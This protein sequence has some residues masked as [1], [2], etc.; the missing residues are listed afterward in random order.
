MNTTFVTA[1]YYVKDYNNP[2]KSIEKYFECF[3]KLINTGILLSVYISPEYKDQ[4]EELVKDHAN[5]KIAKVMAIQDTWVYKTANVG[6]KLPSNR[7]VLKDTFDYM[8]CQ[9]TKIECLYYSIQ[10]NYFN[11]DQFAWIDFGIFHVLND[12]EKAT[13]LLKKIA[14]SQLKDS[15]VFPGC[16][17]K[18]YAYLDGV[19]WRLCGGFFMGNKNKLIDMWKRYQAFLPQFIQ[20]YNLMTW[21]VNLWAAMEMETDFT[22]DWYHADHNLTILNIPQA[23]FLN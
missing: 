23:Y 8:V 21:E 15:L 22:F 18:G 11:T 6:I 2:G 9:N 4:L 3:K 12:F 17:N 20:K 13:L 14:N 1:F 5:V 7:N 10:E 16:W 19:N